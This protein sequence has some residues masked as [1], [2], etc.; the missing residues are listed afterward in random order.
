MRGEQR[1]FS[2][3]G[4]TKKGKNAISYQKTKYERKK[5]I[6]LVPTKPMLITENNLKVHFI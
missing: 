6:L 4:P 3:V 5:K 1:I 2:A